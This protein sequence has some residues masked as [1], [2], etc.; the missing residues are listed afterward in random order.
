MILGDHFPGVL[1]KAKIRDQ[2][3]PGQVVYLHCD[4]IKPNPKNKY[5]LIASIKPQ[6]LL[7]IINTSIHEFISSRP[8]LLAV[9]VK[10]DLENHDFLDHDSYIDCVDT[11]RGFNY[12]ELES[13]LL[14]EMDRLKGPISSDVRAQV[15][16]ATKASI[17]LSSR[18][19]GWIL[20]SL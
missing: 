11:I 8:H 3:I 5:L 15:L 7:Y 6:V 4:F 17:T 16:A 19:Q 12:E 2:L 1:K 18:E 20:V 14:S 13:I 10:I 9:Q